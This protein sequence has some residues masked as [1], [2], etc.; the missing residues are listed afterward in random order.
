MI[1]AAVLHVFALAH[2]DLTLLS[3]N[4][5]MGS[6]ANVLISTRY[7]GEQFNPRYDFP[8]LGLL[9]VGCL[10]IVMLSNKEK[11]EVSLKEL[12]VL[13]TRVQS[14]LYF[15][16]V[17]VVVMMAKYSGPALLVK[18][19][20]FEQD[21]EKWGDGSQ[22]ALLPERV[23]GVERPE[24]VLI[25]TISGMSVDD[26]NQVSPSSAVLKRFIK[27]PLVVGVTG[28]A[29]LVS[30]S[31]LQIKLIGGVVE[32]AQETADYFALIPLGFGV[33]YTATS[34]LTYLNEAMKNYE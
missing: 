13:V 33:A 5:L 27:V 17:Q 1:V 11:H 9:F 8:G 24:R 14:L 22:N 26:V 20:N 10:L 19:R 29:M 28:A 25:A 23:G 3:C 18:L 31:D 34:T 6:I 32:D 16:A 4:A 21:C 7:L 30:L 15:A 2:A 12:T